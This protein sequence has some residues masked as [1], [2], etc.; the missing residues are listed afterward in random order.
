MTTMVQSALSISTRKG[1]DSPEIQNRGK[2]TIPSR[3]LFRGEREIWIIH[4]EEVYR[5]RITSKDRLIL[6]K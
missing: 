5:L 1:I 4:R 3:E 6:T 2:V